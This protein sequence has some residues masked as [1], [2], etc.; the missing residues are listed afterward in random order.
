MARHRLL[1]IED[2]DRIA[3]LVCDV[4]KDSGFAIYKAPSGKELV[5]VYENFDPEVIVLD[6]LMPDVDGFEVMDFL[7]N[8]C[9][10]AVILIMSGNDTYREMA[11]RMA[12]A[13]GLNIS[14]IIPK[15]FR[16]AALRHTLQKVRSHLP[17]EE[18]DTIIEW[19]RSITVQ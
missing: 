7:S 8:R 4:A 13:R 17:P 6:V 1:V 12:V 15:P 10:K 18:T 9:S 16:I 19:K 14:N 5:S 2:D 11:E 3:D